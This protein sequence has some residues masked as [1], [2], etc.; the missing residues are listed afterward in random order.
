MVCLC[1][2]VKERNH[3][4][5]ELCRLLWFLRTRNTYT[6]N[7]LSKVILFWFFHYEHMIV[8]FD[9]ISIVGRERIKLAYMKIL[10]CFVLE[11][12][13]FLFKVIYALLSLQIIFQYLK[14]SSVMHWW[15][16]E[17]LNG[18]KAVFDNFYGFIDMLRLNL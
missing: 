9:F 11:R 16:H 8:L 13:A 15:L 12:N 18:F 4:R 7:D 10:F 17:L 6:Y 14:H 3:M 2:P 5:C 1:I